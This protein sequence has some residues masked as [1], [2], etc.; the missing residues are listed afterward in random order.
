ME[1]R[2]LVSVSRLV[3]RPFLRVSVSKVSGLETLNIAKN[4]FIKISIIKRFFVYCIF[5]QETTETRWKMPE[6]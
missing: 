6:I 1:S 5:R 2:D 4:W 3:L